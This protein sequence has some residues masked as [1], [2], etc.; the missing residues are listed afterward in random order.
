MTYA[1]A[2]Y[3][4]LLTQSAKYYFEQLLFGSF[5]LNFISIITLKNITLTSQAG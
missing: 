2:K 3:A 1:A 4:L 5:T